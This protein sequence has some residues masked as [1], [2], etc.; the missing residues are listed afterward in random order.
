MKTTKPETEKPCK[1]IFNYLDYLRNTHCSQVIDGG[2][3]VQ[4]C[5]ETVKIVEKIASDCL[6]KVRMKP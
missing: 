5:D 2:K 4:Q 1:D 3:S 6:D